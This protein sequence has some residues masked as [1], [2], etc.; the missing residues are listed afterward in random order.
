MERGTE[1]SS[2]GK[3]NTLHIRTIQETRRTTWGKHESN[4]LVLMMK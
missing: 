3:L 1:I 2:V 4:H